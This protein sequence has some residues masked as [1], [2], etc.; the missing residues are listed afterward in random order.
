MKDTESASFNDG[1]IFLLG[2]DVMGLKR[3]TYR[4]FSS[5]GKAKAKY[6][7]YVQEVN[8]D[9]KDPRLM[10]AIHAVTPDKDWP[11][12]LPYVHHRGSYGADRSCDPERCD[13]EILGFPVHLDPHVPTH[14]SLAG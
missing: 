5:S 7:K 10:Y 11:E 9:I 6:G 1:A 8:Q 12:N 3:R 14:S 13:C 2:V 4:Y